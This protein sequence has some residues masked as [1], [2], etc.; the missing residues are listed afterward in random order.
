MSENE[1]ELS[2]EEAD[3]LLMME[4]DYIPDGNNEPTDKLKL[5]ISGG[6]LNI[7]FLSCDKKEKFAMTIFKGR[8]E[9][10]KVSFT[11][12]CRSTVVI[13]RVDITSGEHR[14]PDGEVIHGNH[15]HQ[16]REGYGD[17]FAIP[18]PEYFSAKNTLDRVDKFMD[19]C[20]ITAKPEFEEEIF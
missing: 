19:Y 15:L 14:N 16:Y 7:S 18:L 1:Q 20:H 10:S 12:R 3:R 9:L 8:I 11:H 6:K 13:A 5:P 17:R 2:Q 4:K